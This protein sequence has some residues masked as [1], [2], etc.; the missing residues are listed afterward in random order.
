MAIESD[1]PAFQDANAYYSDP[2]NVKVPDET[3][4]ESA[5]GVTSYLMAQMP[6]DILGTLDAQVAALETSVNT[7]ETQVETAEKNIGVLAL[8]SAVSEG[9]TIFDMVDGFADEFQDESGIDTAAST[10]E[11]Y[12]GV[13]KTYGPAGG[14]PATL[15]IS[16]D[17]TNGSATFIDSIS[18]KTITV[19]GTVQHSTTNAKPSFG[20]TSISGGGTGNYLSLADSEDWNLAADDFTFDMWIRPSTLAPA[21]QAIVAQWGTGKSFTWRLT[22]NNLQFYYSTTGNNFLSAVGIGVMTVDE[23]QHIAAVR[24]GGTLTLYRNGI[25]VGTT[26]IGTDAIYNSPRA[27]TF[28]AE[29]AGATPASACLIDEF[30]FLKGTAVWTSNFT[31]PAL[32]YN[33]SLQNMTLLSLPRTADFEPSFIRA[34]LGHSPVDTVAENV[35]F[36]LRISRDG[37]ATFTDMPLTDEGEFESDED[38][39]TTEAVDVTGQPSGNAVVYEF[40]TAN[41]TDQLLK[42]IYI[43][44]R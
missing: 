39:Y 18:A 2:E 31:P 36:T 9:W 32:P 5:Q 30:R 27:L 37:G 38:I 28:F 15:L 25:S 44:W 11:Q 40:A 24:N 13:A 6:G 10:F 29:D 7:L 23:W 12:D 8:R 22:S 35:D 19:N 16:S 17:T 41:T 33:T 21:D 34:V 42:R 43:Q 4:S 1:N 20:A 3:H 14:D 26:A